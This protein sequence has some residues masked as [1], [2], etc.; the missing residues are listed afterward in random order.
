MTILWCR[1]QSDYLLAMKGT[2]LIIV[3]NFMFEPVYRG[4]GRV[5]YN[6]HYCPC[7]LPHFYPATSDCNGGKQ[8]TFLW[9][10]PILYTPS[11]PPSYM[12]GLPSF[13]PVRYY[14]VAVENWKQQ[15]QFLPTGVVQIVYLKASANFEGIGLLLPN[16][17]F[18][19][20]PL[21]LTLVCVF[22]IGLFMRLFD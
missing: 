1:L 7:N 2:L 18:F 21:F 20:S 19:I 13:Q 3:I 6:A 5:W 11:P 8:A 9:S 16:L 22:L 17:I 14:T 10:T 15:N 4:R 12:G